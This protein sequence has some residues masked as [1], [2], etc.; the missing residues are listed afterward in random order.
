MIFYFLLSLHLGFEGGINKPI[1]GLDYNLENGNIYRIYIGKQDLNHNV[2]LNLVINGSYYYGENPGYS[3]STY[4]AGIMI[5]KIPWRVSPYIEVGITYVT[6]VL[7]K[8]KEWGMSFD[9]TFG[10]LINFYYEN[11]NIYPAFYYY[12]IT[13]FRVHAGIMGMKLGIRYEL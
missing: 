13:D 7:N 6:R 9:Y 1:T 10:F 5:T 12:G 4:G 2:L 3:F 8:S 11:I